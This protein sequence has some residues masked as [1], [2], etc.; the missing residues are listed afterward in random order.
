MNRIDSLP[1]NG[2]L[3]RALSGVLFAAFFIVGDF[4]R[5][6]LATGALPLPGAPAAEVARYVAD[7]R[8]A[9]L[10]V[11]VVQ[12][13]SAIALFVFAGCVVSVVRRAP[14]AGEMLPGLTRTGGILAAALLLASALLSLA[15]IPIAAG[16]DLALVGTVRTLN[17]LSG[18]T[19]H[20]VA[21]G[22][23]AGAA[24]LA[25]HR[26]RALPRW[27]CWLGVVL[28]VPALLSLLSL[29]VYFANAFILL[30]RLLSFVWSIAAGIALARGTRRESAALEG[31]ARRVLA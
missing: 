29:A 28:A 31:G 24:S 2:R 1:T 12:I 9:I 19:F 10:A 15:L 8:A 23:F 25:A 6:A 3:W 5:G 17:F 13:L 22:L 14:G 30:G 20:V 27:I 16:G 21:L 18:G 7:N 4:L 26:S 11:G